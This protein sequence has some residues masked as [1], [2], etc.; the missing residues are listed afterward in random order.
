MTPSELVATIKRTTLP[1]LCVEGV[2]DK[3]ALRLLQH[4]IRTKCTLLCCDGRQN[5]FEVWLRRTEFLGRR[6]SF[7]ADKDLYVFGKVPTEYA[8]IVFTYG[9]S[10]ENDILS[11]GKCRALFDEADR[12]AFDTALALT[13][14]HYWRECKAY[15]EHG[16]QPRWESTFKLVADKAN[17]SFPTICGYGGCGL[18]KRIVTDPCRYLRGKNLLDCYQYALSR[19]DRHARYSRESIVEL[20]CKPRLGRRFTRLIEGIQVAMA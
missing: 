18:Y 13:A 12:N 5:L 8:G 19:R 14:K 16:T 10:L 6:V 17:G 1:T 11:S 9:Y 15:I 20:S 7:L 3:A 4:Q 2:Q